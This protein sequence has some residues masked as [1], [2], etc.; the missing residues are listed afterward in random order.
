MRR[1]RRSS[2]ETS[3]PLITPE[4]HRTC[5]S[6]DRR[7]DVAIALRG[8]GPAE[9]L[10]SEG[11]AGGAVPAATP[12]RCAA[13]AVSR[14]PSAATIRQLPDRSAGPHG[15]RPLRAATRLPSRR[16]LARRPPPPAGPP[17]PVERRRQ[18]RVMA[19]RRAHVIGH[20]RVPSPESQLPRRCGQPG[21][22]TATP[23]HSLSGLERTYSLP[24]WHPGSQAGAHGAMTRRSLHHL[25]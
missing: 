7:W 17:A 23:R 5:T 13:S 1:A 22:C 19:R 16:R 3:Q 14:Q 24:T 11:A 6:L 8:T 20:V 9:S 25:H 4:P 18:L 12:G 15:I 21:P 2:G 10:R